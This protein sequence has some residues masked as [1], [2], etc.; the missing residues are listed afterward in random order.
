MD[1]MYYDNNSS[2]SDNLWGVT[3]ATLI[4]GESYSTVKSTAQ[5]GNIKLGKNNVQANLLD[6]N[7]G[8]VIE[9][10]LL[11]VD[12]HKNWNLRYYDGTQRYLNFPNFDGHHK[13]TITNNRQVFEV[14]G[15]V[16]QTFTVNLPNIYLQSFAD[17]NNLEFQFKQ[18]KV[19]P[20]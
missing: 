6:G 20:I 8:V 4:R 19:Y 13:V 9:C 16:K 7:T 18:L 3:N 5:W 12:A 14:D 2:A 15:V 17:A 10:D 1:A 11:G